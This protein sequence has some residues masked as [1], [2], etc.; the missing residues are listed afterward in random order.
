MTKQATEM[1]KGILE[2]IVLGILAGRPAYGYEI[3]AWLR[4][5]GYHPYI[6]LETSEEAPFRAR[7]AGTSPAGNLDWP[8]KYEVDRDDRFD[9]DPDPDRVRPRLSLTPTESDP[10]PLSWS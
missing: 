1:L 9:S 8:P 3:T 7:F 6:L 10:N 2:G 4:D 5:Q